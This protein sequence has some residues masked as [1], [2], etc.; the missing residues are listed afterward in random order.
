MNLPGF[1]SK[2][3]TIIMYPRKKRVFLTRIKKF[4]EP[5]QDFLRMTWITCDQDMK[6]EKDSMEVMPTPLQ[7][8]DH[9]RS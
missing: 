7:Q 9:I 1:I 6:R 2:I 8:R 5:D 3:L 4:T